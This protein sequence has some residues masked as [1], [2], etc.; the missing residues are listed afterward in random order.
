MFF[1][2]SAGKFTRTAMI[3]GLLAQAGPMLE[4]AQ[5]SRTVPMNFEQARF[6]MVEQQIRPWE[7]LDQQVLQVIL[8][9]PR[10]DYVPAAYRS[11]AFA[12]T[13]I[14]LGQ[15]QV[16]MIPSVEGR[17]LQ[18]LSLKKTDKVLEI[19]TGSGYLTACLAALSGHVESVDILP[20]FTDSA[21][22]KL[23]AHG[24]ANVSLESG[25]A[26]EG[27]KS[28]AQYDAIA[29]TGSVPVIPESYKKALTVNGRLFVIVGDTSMPIMSA[30]LVTRVTD[31]Q[32]VQES[33]FET[34]IPPLLNAKK[35]RTFLFR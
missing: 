14:P 25:D 3:P 17:L 22:K 9:T 32:W 20:E 12:D 11:L 33:L 10:E 29:I 28:G 23:S 1:P 8:H 19:G 26:A 7:V 6:N 4:C 18:A 34:G 15:G 30:C 24:V 2:V 5:F 31:N 27:W 21:S 16:M 13:N 35:T